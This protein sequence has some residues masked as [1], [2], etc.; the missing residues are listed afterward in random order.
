MKTNLLPSKIFT[1]SIL[2]VLGLKLAA[3]A[4]DTGYTIQANFPP[5][6]EFS[7]D[8][9]DGN[10]DFLVGGSFSLQDAKLVFKGDPNMDPGYYRFVSWTGGGNPGGNLPQ[11]ENSNYFENFTTSID[12][13]WDDRAETWAYGLIFCATE[14]ANG[15]DN[16]MFA[17]N[18]VGSY[19]VVKQKDG[20]WEDIV[21]WTRTSV[22]NTNSTPNKLTV[23]K[24]GPYFYFFINDVEV[25][26]RLIPDMHGGGVG[27]F[28]YHTVDV[29][30]D[31]FSVERIT[32]DD[33]IFDNNNV[34]EDF[35]HGTGGFSESPYFSLSNNRFKFQG[36]GSEFSYNK[37]WK[38]GLNPGGW[39]TSPNKSDYL[40]DF[41]FSVDT[42]W[43][44]GEYYTCGVIVCTEGDSAETSDE[45][46]FI[47]DGSSGVYGILSYK[48]G[49][50]EILVDW[51]E[52]SA[53][54]PTE[55]RLEVHKLG[56]I[57]DFYINS[58]R[59]EHLTIDAFPGGGVGLIAIDD[60][61]I[62]LDNIT[63]N[64]IG[65][66]PIADAGLTSGG[67]EEQSIMLDGSDSTD[68]TGISSFEW[69]QL[70]GP[71]VI[72]LNPNTAQ[73][74]FTA[75]EV[76]QNGVNMAFQLTIQDENNL[77]GSDISLVN[78]TCEDTKGD[79]DGNCEI[80]LP[81]AILALK[82]VSGEDSSAIRSD[83][84]SSVADVDNNDKIG[85]AETLYILDSIVD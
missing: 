33:I 44:G 74:T 26:R 49:V 10:G 20:V 52:T 57:F 60:S 32:H 78:V 61:E 9:N 25:A 62:S 66:P 50:F 36:D 46:N 58:T 73:P 72:L 39:N 77:R 59:V 3:V 29:S 13:I 81:D 80:E 15:R 69:L 7:E 85:I 6:I 17:I 47:I 30:F 64:R 75:P 68:D 54:S 8:F 18:K 11:P 84:A 51:T 40:E 82:V 43:D 35:T 83:Y 53:I 21:D 23:K 55:N 1:L 67:V 14:D 70:S 63:I 79:V 41:T 71:P 28:A 5:Y 24:V 76:G 27:A 34:V 31:N 37:L 19:V 12:T 48:D 38:G 2:F 45:I 56:N 22:L 4:G 16:I 42:Y 65:N